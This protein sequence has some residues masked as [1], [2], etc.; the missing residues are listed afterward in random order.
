MCKV[1]HLAIETTIRFM[2]AAKL[3]PP[4]HAQLSKLF[5]TRRGC[6]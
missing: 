5:A 1:P 6:Y 3:D 2:T 4:L